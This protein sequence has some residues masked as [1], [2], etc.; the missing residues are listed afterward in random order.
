M[1]GPGRPEQRLAADH[2]LGDRVQEPEVERVGR[3]ATGASRL[4]R[5]ASCSVPQMP[6][7]DDVLPRRGVGVGARP[8]VSTVTT[9]NSES[10]A[11][12]SAQYRTPVTDRPAEHSFGETEPDGQLEVV[13][14]RAHRGRHERAVELDRHR[15]LDD[16]FVRLAARRGHGPDSSKVT[17]VTSARP[18]RPRDDPAMASR[19]WRSWCVCA[20]HECTPSP[21]TKCVN[22]CAAGPRQAPPSRRPGP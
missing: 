4:H 13:T 10:T 3:R 11:L 7:L 6:Q 12:P 18:V 8:P 14:G 21:T 20:W 22:D 17:F 19:Y 15:F 2:H 5:S 1:G 9:L 16:Q